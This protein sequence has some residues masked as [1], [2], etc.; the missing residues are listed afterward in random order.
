MLLD[1]AV[2]T[3]VVAIVG[4]T[5]LAFVP[6][7]SA[8]VRVPTLI[9]AIEVVSTKMCAAVVVAVPT[10]VWAA[11]IIAFVGAFPWHYFTPFRDVWGH[12]AMD[13]AAA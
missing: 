8:C 9:C 10:G 1:Y 4:A 12:D 2:A 3:T 6:T 7:T 13:N 5:I 11:T